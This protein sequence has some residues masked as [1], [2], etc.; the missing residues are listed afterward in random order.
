M[1]KPKPI[2]PFK[3][4]EEEAHF[5]N[6]HD[7]SAVFEDQKTPLSSLPLLESEKQEVM[8]VRLQASVKKRLK[9]IA[10]VKGINPSTLSRM[11]LIEKMREFDSRY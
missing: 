10:Q 1:N 11:W 6:T 3:N 4:L 8:T 5:W 7:V 9:H 2:Q